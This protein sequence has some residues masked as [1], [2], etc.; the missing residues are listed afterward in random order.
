MNTNLDW[1][2]STIYKSKSQKARVTTEN[3]V[4]TSSF[5][6]TCGNDSLC[7]HPTNKPVADFYCTHCNEEFELKSK[8]SI[9]QYTDTL[10]TN[11]A[12]YTM[13]ERI[14]SSNNPNLLFMIHNKKV[15]TNFLLIPKYFFVP[16]IIEK[17]KPLG[18]QARRAGWIG[19]NINL[20]NVP[21]VGKI[22][23]I[24][25]GVEIKKSEV[26]L[27]YELSKPLYNKDIEYRGWLLDVLLCVDRLGTEF[28]LNQIYDFENELSVKHPGNSFVREKIRQQLQKL[29]DAGYIEFLGKGR[30]GKK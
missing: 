4:H 14:T 19:C 18:P 17:R 25:N 24:R 15:V 28:T 22:F 27:Q 29:R 30:Y 5:C 10:I 26:V 13:V 11:G 1:T 12:Y 21:S 2:I 6:P 3:W 20:H 9:R 8:E 23:I 7:Q 16:A